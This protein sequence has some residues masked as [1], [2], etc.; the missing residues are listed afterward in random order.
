M[1]FSKPSQLSAALLFLLSLPVFLLSLTVHADDKDPLN[2]IVG[3]SGQHDS[4]IFRVPSG[5]ALSSSLERWDNITTVY[6]GVRIDKL[7]AMQRFKFDSTLTAYRYQNNSFLDFEA[8]DYK[9]AWLWYLTPYLRGTLSADRTQQQNSFQDFRNFNVSNVNTTENQHFEADFSPYGNWH[10]LGGLTRSTFTNSQNFN[11]QSNFS[12]NSLD[13]GLRYVF[14]SGTTITLMGHDR[15][16]IYGRSAPDPFSLLD[17]A[18]DETEE[19]ANLDWLITG[20]SRI[21]LHTAYMTHEEDHFSQRDFSGMVGRMEYD[22][23][24][25][26]KL[27]LAVAAS[28]ELSNFQTIDSSYTRDDTLSVSPSYAVSDKITMRA[29]ASVSQRT[30]LGGGLIPSSDRVDTGKLASVGIYWSPLRSITTGWEPMR[31]VSIGGNLQRSSRSSTSPG[32]DFS[33]TTAEITANLFF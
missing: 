26:A 2:V 30:F 10:L 1:A 17:T 21:I 15:R 22:W 4:N 7:Y 13:A 9:A 32:L 27:Q 33:D 24:P 3:V 8:K 18:Y 5:M 20:K 23:T 31:N 16:G 19:E 12:L 14:P 25:T 28:S 11:P 29:S 6:A